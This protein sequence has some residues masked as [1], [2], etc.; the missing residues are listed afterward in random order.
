MT[1]SQA[2]LED[3]GSVQ[4]FSAHA[5]LGLDEARRAIDGWLDKGVTTPLIRTP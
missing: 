1:R 2:Q 3:R 5:G 4:L